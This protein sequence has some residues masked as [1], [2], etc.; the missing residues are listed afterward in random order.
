MDKKRDKSIEKNLSDIL[1][2]LRQQGLSASEILD[3]VNRLILEKSLQDNLSKLSK[4]GLDSSEITGLVEKAMA[5]PEYATVPLSAFK[6]SRLSSL[7]IIVKYL[8]ENLQLSFRHISLLTGR[9]GVALAVT[10]RNARIKHPAKFS[11]GSSVYDIPVSILKNRRLSVL[12]NI[13][14]FLKVSFSLTYHQIA[15][16]LNRDDRTIWTVYQRAIRKRGAK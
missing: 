7:E 6:L 1:N 10:Y 5:V 11:A 8:R 4:K 15:V 2:Y 14:L 12:E 3:T 13:V 16:L 9:N